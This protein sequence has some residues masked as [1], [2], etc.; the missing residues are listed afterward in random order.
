MTNTLLTKLEKKSNINIK[1]L[2]IFNKDK[3]RDSLEFYVKNQKFLKAEE[4]LR[5]FKINFNQDQPIAYA[6][7]D[8]EEKI[9]GFLGTIFSFQPI[10][11]KF[12]EHC[13]LHS[14][15][16]NEQFRLEA[17]KLILPIIKKN[18]FI[19]TYFPIKTLEGLYKKLG[20]EE[21]Q[22][23]SKIIFLL[24]S[25]K[26]STNN[27]NL[28][29]DNNY[30][31]KYLKE[32]DKI[33]LKDHLKTETRKIF[34]HFNEDLFNNI[35]IVVKEKKFKNV[36]SYLEVIYI[37]DQKIF[38]I[39]KKKILFELSK[40]FKTLFLKFNY[41]EKDKE[42]FKS[43]YEIKNSRKKIFYLNKP[44]DFKINFLYSELL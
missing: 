39:H 10:K 41:F 17:F 40:K 37:S 5:I 34:I 24:P 6:L 3:K 27:L 12:V 21:I 22:F 32:K 15:V 19:S 25:F 31:E 14:W 8:N 26:F 20:F 30:Y 2:P 23:F 28:I 16:V 44:L 43:F 4:V 7:L 38:K 29:E 36:I 9:V 18:I 1:V 35:L 33:F 13:Y 11:E 42:I